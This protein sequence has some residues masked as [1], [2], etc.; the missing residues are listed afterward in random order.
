M[1]VFPESLSAAL[2]QQIMW[3]TMGAA[4]GFVFSALA[5]FKVK[6][7]VTG[8][9]LVLSLIGLNIEFWILS[10]RIDRNIQEKEENRTDSLLRSSLDAVE[11]AADTV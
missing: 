5:C 2:I 8:G 7:F 1:A 11:I 4:L 6:L 3:G 10:H 9:I